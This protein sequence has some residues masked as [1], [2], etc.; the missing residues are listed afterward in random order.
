MPSLNERESQLEA[1][2]A[3]L[4]YFGDMDE[5]AD[6]FLRLIDFEL[7]HAFGDEDSSE[8]SDEDVSD[9]LLGY[10]RRGLLL[11]PRFSLCN[12]FDPT[13]GANVRLSRN[14]VCA[15][16]TSSFNHVLVFSSRPLVENRPF[17]VSTQIADRRCVEDAVTG[18]RIV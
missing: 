16:R 1:G 13:C 14:R 2:S 11:H 18:L 4:D 9:P 17:T 12:L 15:T 7:E 3:P 8:D 6:A 5:E 10:D